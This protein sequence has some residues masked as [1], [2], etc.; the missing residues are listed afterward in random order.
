MFIPLILEQILAHTIGFA[1]SVMVAGAGESVLS[2]VSLVSTINAL[3]TY[4]FMAMTAGGSVVIAQILGSGNY[5]GARH[6]S[7]QL[8]WASFI[9]ATSITV[10]AMIF[11]RQILSF[12]FGRVDDEVMN[13]AAVYFFIMV[14]TYPLSAISGSCSSML[15]VAGDTKTSMYISVFGNVLNVAGNAVLII[16]FKLGAAGAAISSLF[17][18]LVMAFV[19][20]VIVHHKNDMIYIDNIFRFKPDWNLFGRICKIG[21]PN[22]L[23][24]SIFQLGKILTLSLV[25]GFGTYQI[26]AN[27]VSTTITNF[28]YIPGG[29]MGVILVTVVGRCIGAGE[30]LQAKK[31]AAKLV[32]GVY[33]LNALV[34]LVTCIFADELFAIYNLSPE[35][36]SV[37]KQLL[38]IHS[39]GVCTFWPMG[40]TVTSAFRAA[41]DVRYC[42]VISVLCMWICR[43][44][45]SYVF[46]SFLNMGVVG[47]W[48]AMLC[49]WIVRAILFT[50]RYFRGT[51]LKKYEFQRE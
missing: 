36:A 39:I 44:G 46:A 10:V 47:V 26:A 6:A 51:W 17:S 20:L 48:Y 42:M 29:A 21:I 9:V 14:L 30:K 38:Y 41:S 8:V 35:S 15:R 34:A 12:A 4:L 24:N 5:S 19:R 16:G 45:L 11:H 23:E 25:S 2:G 33:V 7:K 13:S 18:S 50:V 49:D 22:G 1:D 31:Y 43:I 37:A 27:S 28:Q 40:F 3:A 32:G